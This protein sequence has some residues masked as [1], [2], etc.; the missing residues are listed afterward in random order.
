MFEKL[1]KYSGL[2]ATIII[3][4]VLAFVAN[5]YNSA[6]KEREVQGKFVELAVDILK[7]KPTKENHNIRIW[8]TSILDM[9]SGVPMSDATIDDLVNNVSMDVSKDFETKAAHNTV[10]KNGGMIT[11]KIKASSNHTFDYTAEFLAN[12]G[13]AKQSLNESIQFDPTLIKDDNPLVLQI[14]INNLSGDSN[15]PYAIEITCEQDGVMLSKSTLAGT[16]AENGDQRTQ[17]I[18]LD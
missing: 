8:A 4:I 9:Y 12:G 1:N 3:P 5:Q 14:A 11:A 16:I 10:N 15:T 17:I 13:L 6:I 18:K 2:I 7:Q